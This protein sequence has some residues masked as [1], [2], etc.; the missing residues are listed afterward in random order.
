MSSAITT[1]GEELIAQKIGNDSILTIDRFVLAHVPGLDPDLAVDRSEQRPA[2]ETI[3]YEYDIP[4]GDKGYVN[5]NQVVYSM[6]LGSDIGNFDFNWLGLEST[7]DDTVVAISYVPDTTKWKTDLATNTLGN[8]LTRNFLLEFT[9]AQA[10]TGIT[11]TAATWQI[12]FTARLK[13]IDERERRSNRDIYGR[14]CFWGDSWAVVNDGGTFRLEPGIGYVEGLRLY[15]DQLQE[16]DPGVLPKDVWLDVSLQAQGSD[17]APVITPVFAT[18]AQADY[19]DE[20]SAVHYL[21]KI[22][23]IDAAGLVTDLRRTEVIGSDVIAWMRAHADRTDN[24]HGVTTSQIGAETPAGAQAK[25]DAH[26]GSTNPHSATAEAT[27]NRIALRDSSGDMAARL[28]RSSYG[29]G[30]SPIA[31]FM[32]QVNQGAD[33]Y[34]RPTSLARVRSFLGRT[35]ASGS[36]LAL[37]DASG[38]LEAAAGVSGNDL[39]NWNQ[40]IASKAASGYQ[41][42]PSGVLIQW[43]YIA[44]FPYG[45]AAVVF[46]TAF[47]STNYVIAGMH[48]GSGAAFLCESAGTRTTTGVTVYQ[49]DYGAGAVGNAS[50][51]LLIGY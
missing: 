3:V 28:F 12:D 10:C 29:D 30:S 19:T 1:L 17:V 46:P 22:A 32:G 26:S 14:A 37:R 33:N 11:V 16:I 34:I 21:E 43:L 50:R 25:V 18:T 35:D 5:P 6:L 48:I 23:A 20:N 51:I 44:S 49:R 47:S 41:R 9:G 36:Y 31:Y 39:V 45:N 42:F 27:P 8:N 7:A 24:P 4:A 40:F 13:G 2:P 15:R 38:R